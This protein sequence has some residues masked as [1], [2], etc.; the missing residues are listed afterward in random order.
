VPQETPTTILRWLRAYTNVPDLG[1]VTPAVHP[2][3]QAIGAEVW[4]IEVS[5]APA[6]LRGPLVLRLGQDAAQMRKETAFRDGIAACTDTVS[7]PATRAMGDAAAGPGRPFVI[8]ERR[9]GHHLIVRTGVAPIMAATMAVIH[10]LP[11]DR[12]A[13]ALR[14]ASVP[15][16]RYRQP[17]NV[18][19]ERIERCI[20]ECDVST[21]RPVLEW[22]VSN[23]PAHGDDVVCH[24]DL[25]FENVLAKHDTVIAVIDWD[26]AAIGSRWFDVARTVASL[27]CLPLYGRRAT[28]RFRAAYRQ[29][30]GWDEDA[31][32]WHQVLRFTSNL[33]QVARWRHTR[34]AADRT[35]L[36]YFARTTARHLRDISGFEVR[37]PP[38]P[39]LGTRLLEYWPGLQLVMALLAAS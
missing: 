7:V 12:V 34:Q 30:A 21:L 31:Y 10:R 4:F 33:A 26:E 20:V 19:L 17:H 2:P 18:L 27:A 1:Y 16:S 25:V 22:L 36:D 8:M 39:R 23:R 29:H 11:A 9:S 6:H 15:D 32:R 14:R 24:G 5:P 13:N 35:E 3:Q 28:D 38:T 37:L